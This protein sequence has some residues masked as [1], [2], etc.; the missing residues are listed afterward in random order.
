MIAP[1]FCQLKC[2]GLD[3][4]LALVTQKACVLTLALESLLT[5]PL[6]S[7]YARYVASYFTHPHS[8]S[9]VSE[10]QESWRLSVC[11]CVCCVCVCVAC[12]CVQRDAYTGKQKAVRCL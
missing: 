2:S 3:R 1:A 10:S 6:R 9:C 7:L 12:V 11:V 8:A 5:W 4:T